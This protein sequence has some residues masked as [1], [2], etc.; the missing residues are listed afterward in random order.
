MTRKSTTKPSASSGFASELAVKAASKLRSLVKVVEDL[1]GRSPV[2]GRSWDM[3]LN[4]KLIGHVN[5]LDAKDGLR[6]GTSMIDE[7]YR[8]LGLGKKFYGE[9]MRRAPAQTLYSDNDVSE[10]A[11]RVW[12]SFIKRPETYRAAIGSFTPERL[13]LL[14]KAPSTFKATLV[15]TIPQLVEKAA[16]SVGVSS[17]THKPGSS[18]IRQLMSSLASNRQS[19]WRYGTRIVPR[20][21]AEGIAD[22]GRESGSGP[23]PGIAA[24]T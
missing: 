3:L 19:A 1:A 12:Q 23:G 11:R 17:G 15:K 21:V 2:G 24:A 16:K 4:N 6:V 7:A 13:R 9:L 22:D 18:H 14:N 20:P 8:G 10:A 5:T